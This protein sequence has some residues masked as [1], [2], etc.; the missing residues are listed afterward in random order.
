M[1]AVGEGGEELLGGGGWG[2]RG[3][4]R[5][6]RRGAAHRPWPVATLR[7]V[8]VFPVW[9]LRYSLQ[10]KKGTTKAN[11]CEPLFHNNNERTRS[12]NSVHIDT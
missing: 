3:G 10:K 1:D 9:Y 6:R 5:G 2:G 12:T 8:V 4:D 11:F 7:A